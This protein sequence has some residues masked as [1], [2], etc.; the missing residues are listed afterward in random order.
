MQPSPISVGLCNCLEVPD[1]HALVL[2]GCGCDSTACIAVAVLILP[3]D[4]SDSVEA[5]LG[6]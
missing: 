4:S 1:N 2:D 3:N 6:V 5:N